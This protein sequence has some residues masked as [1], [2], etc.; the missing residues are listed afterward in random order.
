MGYRAGDLVSCGLFLKLSGPQKTWP[1]D[2]SFWK[3]HSFMRRG[4]SKGNTQRWNRS[5]GWA[6]N[7]T[8]LIENFP[9]LHEVWVLLQPLGGT[10][11][12]VIGLSTCYL[13]N[14]IATSAYL[15]LPARVQRWPG[16]SILDSSPRTTFSGIDPRIFSSPLLLLT[17]DS[18][19][20]Y[21]MD[22]NPITEIAR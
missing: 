9:C 20:N 8:A 1:W 10:Y 21:C 19:L 4:K 11:S 12:Q 18:Y 13:P 5:L 14:L 6:A 17:S 16:A 7:L 15:A 22:K 2:E 3:V